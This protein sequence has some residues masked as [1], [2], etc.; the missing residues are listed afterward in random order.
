MR[1]LAL[2]AF[3][4]VIAACAAPVS[5]PAPA[6]PNQTG[7]LRDKIKHVVVIMQENRSFDEYFG[8]YPGAEGI[9][10]QNGVPTVC[11][12]DPMTSQ[13]V[14]PYHDSQDVNAGGPHGAANAA[15]DINSG[16]MD[17]FIGVFRQGQKACTN[18]DTPGCTLGT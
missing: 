2:L 1:K 13:C 5:A 16:R 10:M 15:A 14:K 3:V 7:L 4:T 11:V 6:N 12:P 17:G 18:T 9:P 8:T